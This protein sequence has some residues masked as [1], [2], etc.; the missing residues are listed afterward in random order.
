MSPTLNLGIDTV[1]LI[2]ASVTLLGP[3][4]YWLLTDA[5][6]NPAHR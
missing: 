1:L 5:R 3:L 4:F 6:P 2:C